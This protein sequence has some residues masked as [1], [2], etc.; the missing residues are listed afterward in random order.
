MA[1][2]MQLIVVVLLRQ[3]AVVILLFYYGCNIGLELT[4]RI[5]LRC[6][7]IGNMEKVVTWQI[8]ATV[9]SSI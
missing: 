2:S 3:L 1:F 7:D 8:P 5:S 6:E 4:Y 9:Q